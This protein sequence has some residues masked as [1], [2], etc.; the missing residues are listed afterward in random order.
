MGWTEGQMAPR[1]EGMKDVS[2]GHKI[3]R[4]RMTVDRKVSTI[5]QC[6]VCTVLYCTVERFEVCYGVSDKCDVYCVI[7]V[8]E[9]I[10]HYLN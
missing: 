3:H 2:E 6:Y 7:L 5:E 4:Y 9:F 10:C 1:M 8:M